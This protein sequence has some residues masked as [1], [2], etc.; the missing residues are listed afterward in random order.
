MKLTQ[1]TSYYQTK[2]FDDKNPKGLKSRVTGS[3][4]VIFPRHFLHLLN[5]PKGLNVWRMIIHVQYY[6]CL[7]VYLFLL[8]FGNVLNTIPR[9]F[10]LLFLCYFIAFSRPDLY[11]SQLMGQL[12][13]IIR[14]IYLF[15]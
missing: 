14:F 1:V 11:C 6:G 15:K 3:L 2:L 5:L 13:E 12:H 7:V 9:D 8:L 4:R 10:Y